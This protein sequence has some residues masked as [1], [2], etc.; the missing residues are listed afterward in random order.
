MRVTFDELRDYYVVYRSYFHTVAVLVIGVV[1]LLV[2][3]EKQQNRQLEKTQWPQAE[4]L[5]LESRIA[6]RYH[7][8][9]F[10]TQSDVFG[11]VTLRIRYEVA[12][13]EV[14]TFVN[15]EVR[16][17]PGSDLDEV[18]AV[19]HKVPIRYDPEDLPAVSLHPAAVRLRKQR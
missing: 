16:D 10:S 1:L 12:G 2:A 18:F 5:I 3:F 4:A 11:R 19:G 9:G 15:E 6:R 8:E 17:A 14:T 13:R 7:R